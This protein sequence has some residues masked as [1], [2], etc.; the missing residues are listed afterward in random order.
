MVRLVQNDTNFDLN[1]QL[2]NSDGTAYDI[3]GQTAVQFKMKL[4]GGAI[5]ID[6]A[7][8]VD[9][10]ADGQVHY[11]FAGSNLDTVGTYETEIQV[12]GPSTKVV[13]FKGDLIQVV[14]EFA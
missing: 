4:V 10:E 3:T 1:F 14:A 6:S 8:T 5:K 11:T 7:M 13:T 12:T 9:S 2:K